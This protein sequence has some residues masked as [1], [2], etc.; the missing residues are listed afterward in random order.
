M[1]FFCR[2]SFVALA[3]NI[4][5]LNI[6]TDTMTHIRCHYKIQIQDVGVLLHR[7]RHLDT[8]FGNDSNYGNHDDHSNS[9]T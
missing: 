1:R 2:D 3:K 9:R 5:Y 8:G 6:T 4:C 7:N